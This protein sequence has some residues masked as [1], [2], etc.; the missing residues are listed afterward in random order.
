[1]N[2]EEAL[3]FAL[4]LMSLMAHRNCSKKEIMTEEEVELLCHHYYCPVC[5]V[6]GQCEDQPVETLC[7]V[8]GECI[9]KHLGCSNFIKNEMTTRWDMFDVI[10]GTLESIWGTQQQEEEKR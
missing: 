10:L 5:L 3:I 6:S 7:P 9:P 8:W 2:T 4:R 1:M